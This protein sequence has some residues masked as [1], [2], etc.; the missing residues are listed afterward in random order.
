MKPGSPRRALPS[1]T[2]PH[3]S[4]DCRAVARMLSRIGDKWT[5]LVIQ[6]LGHGPTRF[7]DLRRGVDGISQRMLTLTLRM[8]ERDGLILRH[9]H[10]SVPPRVEYEL[11]PLGCSLL[12]AVR[13]LGDWAVA[14]GEAVIRAQARY[15]RRQADAA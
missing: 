5:I 2:A 1:R 6:Q 9:V 4:S 14:N 13:V 12:K 11:T 8:L 15:D 10:P 7:N 3:L